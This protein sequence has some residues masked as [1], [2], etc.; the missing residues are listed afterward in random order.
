MKELTRISERGITRT[1]CEFPVA[2]TFDD[3][4]RFGRDLMH[5]REAWQ[6]AAADWLNFG[7]HSYGQKYDMALEVLPV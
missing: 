2:M 1:G 5:V 3:W 7:K 4:L 6:W